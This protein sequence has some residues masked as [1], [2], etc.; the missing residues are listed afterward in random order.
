[1]TAK[2]HILLSTLSPPSKI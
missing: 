2:K 1:V